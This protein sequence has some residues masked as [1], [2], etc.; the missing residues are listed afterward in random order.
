MPEPPTV[1]FSIGLDAEP[2]EPVV[3]VLARLLIAVDERRGEEGTQAERIEN[4]HRNSNV[5]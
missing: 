2:T 3:S 1:A 4:E 5:A